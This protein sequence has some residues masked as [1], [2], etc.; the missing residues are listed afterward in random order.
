MQGTP[1]RDSLPDVVVTAIIGLQNAGWKAYPLDPRLAFSV[2]ADP[3]E[4]DTTRL[5]PAEATAWLGGAA[6]ARVEGEGRSAGEGRG[7]PLWSI[8]LAVAAALFLAEG[9]LLA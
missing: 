5:D 9:L 6:L 8:Q 7:L 1:A 2:L 3:R 4:S